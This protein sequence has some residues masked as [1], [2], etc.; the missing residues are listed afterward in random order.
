M[1]ILKYNLEIAV[2]VCGAVVMIYE[3]IGSRI[4]AP[5]FGNS[6]FVW[7]SLI[8]IILGS[9][10]LGYYFGGKISD[11][12]PNIKRLSF[13]IL[14]AAIF[15]GLTTL[16]KDALLIL[17]EANFDDIK[18]SSILGSI[19][20]FLPTS[21]L[22]GMVSPYSAKLKINDLNNSGSTIG[23]LYA[24]STAGSIAGT[25]ISG[26]YLIPRFGTNKLLIML[27][28]TLVAISLSLTAEFLK[29][30]FAA[31]ALLIL[32]WSTFSQLQIIA[33]KNG[34][35]DIDTTY[36]RI[37]IYDQPEKE[38]GKTRRSL[39]IN[40]DMNSAMI[41]GSD[42]LVFEYT[43]F[44]HLAKY[45]NPDLR[46]ALMIG[47]G[48]FS[49]PKNF[50]KN[51]PEA[52][53]DV[54]EIDPT[55]TEIA[56]KYF[57]LKEDARLNIYTED[58]RVFL[59]KNEKKYDVI[60]GDAFSSHYS[61]PHQL[62]TKEA[63]QKTYD[64][65]NSGGFTI[66]NTISAIDGEKGQ[67]FRAELATYKSVFPQVYVFPVNNMTNGSEVQN[68]MIVALK[69][70]N[71]PDFKSKDPDINTLLSHLLKRDIVADKPILTDDYAPVEYYIN[72][73]S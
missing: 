29:A 61:I 73:T 18:I 67:F 69:T 58:G 62:T 30:K 63:V 2:F 14:L 44:Y 70:K 6:I 19:I 31:L 42:E 39:A 17:L 41:L 64:S 54:V 5:Y 65:L 45:L 40:K 55:V 4:L 11:K 43:K 35:I 24:L 16:S 23:N 53:M 60:F 34:F 37:W 15:I 10:S 51:Y 66:L 47:G 46:A 32:M 7:T 21:L 48:G 50:L 13:I 33:Q 52:T 71:V 68:I 38:T 3:L 27:S 26:F 56:K 25:F 20:L 1:K 72:K 12:N 49:F 8:G 9:L 59:N 22:L 36:S 57:D 28:L